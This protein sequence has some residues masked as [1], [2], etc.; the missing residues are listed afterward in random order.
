MADYMFLFWPAVEWMLQCIA[1][2]ASEVS[3]P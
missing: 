1:Y 3:V 2:K